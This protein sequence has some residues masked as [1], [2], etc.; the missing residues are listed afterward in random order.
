MVESFAKP[1]AAP[2]RISESS[3]LSAGGRW[4]NSMVSVAP[5]GEAER[6]WIYLGRGHQLHGDIGYRKRSDQRDETLG[7]GAVGKNPSL[8]YGRP[9]RGDGRAEAEVLEPPM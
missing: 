5:V 2:H 6:D 9:G 1:E 7:G 8:E 4:L 3:R